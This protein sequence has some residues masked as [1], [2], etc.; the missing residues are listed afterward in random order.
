M[1]K[2]SQDELEHLLVQHNLWQ[3]SSGS[4]GTRMELPDDVDLT[5]AD[6]NSGPIGEGS[7]HLYILVPEIREARLPLAS[8]A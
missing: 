7:A 2:M 1:V 5:S 8:N 6:L 4:Q 3:T